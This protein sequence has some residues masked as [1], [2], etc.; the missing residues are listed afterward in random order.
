VVGAVPAPRHEFAA[1]RFEQERRVV[2]SRHAL[3]RRRVPVGLLQVAA[4]GV[5]ARWYDFLAARAS[6]QV[7]ERV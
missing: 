6:I 1:C 7:R 2:H 4:A 5:V 3:S